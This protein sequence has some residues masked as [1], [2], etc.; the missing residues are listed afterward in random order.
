MPSAVEISLRHAVAR[1]VVN[2]AKAHPYKVV[3]LGI[4][5]QRDA[6]THA[7]YLQRHVHQSLG[8]PLYIMEFFEITAAFL[9][10]KEAVESVIQEPV[11]EYF[12][13]KIT[14]LKR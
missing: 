5:A 13:K 1:E 2:R 14:A 9:S 10:D 11:F 7:L 12:E 4:L 6:Q 3:A 8:I